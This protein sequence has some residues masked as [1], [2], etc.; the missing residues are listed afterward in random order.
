[1][2]MRLDQAAFNVI[3]LGI[4]MGLLVIA[5]ELHQRLWVAAPFLILLGAVGGFSWCL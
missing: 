4:G 2:K 1:M 3:P 5:A